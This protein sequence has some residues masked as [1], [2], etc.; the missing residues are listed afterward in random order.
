MIVSTSGIELS[1]SL[2]KRG[3]FRKL[4]DG[5]R[6]P[7]LVNPATDVHLG[8]V[9]VDIFISEKGEIYPKI[10]EINFVKRV[11]EKK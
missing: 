8:H 9:T 5:F 3:W 11:D 10:K 4:I 7:Q 2:V 1:L 6:K